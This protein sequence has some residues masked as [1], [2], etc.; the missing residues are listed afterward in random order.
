MNVHCPASARYLKAVLKKSHRNYVVIVGW[1]AQLYL[2]FSEFSEAFPSVNVHR[3]A[4]WWSLCSAVCACG[5]SVF[6]EMPSH[7]F[8]LFHS[9]KCLADASFS[10][11][12]KSTRI[13]RDTVMPPWGCTSLPPRNQSNLFRQSH[14][15]YLTLRSPG[16]AWVLHLAVPTG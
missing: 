6:L 3:L 2:C 11:W 16:L 8:L 7:V 9:H 15:P 14:H 5:V 1:T 12:I 4:V 10:Y 13:S